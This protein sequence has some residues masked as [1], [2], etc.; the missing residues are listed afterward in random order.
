MRQR[1]IGQ[2]C[3]I[4]VN[5]ERCAIAEIIGGEG[6]FNISMLGEIQRAPQACLKRAQLN[7][8]DVNGDGKLDILTAN[9]SANDFSVMLGKGTGN[10]QQQQRFVTGNR[11]SGMSV[12]DLNGDGKPDVITGNRNGNDVSVILHR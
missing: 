8:I 1:R 6:S 11:P 12:A 7:T 3:G 4:P 9:A 5:P 10:F 2:N